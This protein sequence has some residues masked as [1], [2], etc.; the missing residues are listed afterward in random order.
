MAG[1]G[2]YSPWLRD[3]SARPAYLSS[4]GGGISFLRG[5]YGPDNAKLGDDGD[6]ERRNSPTWCSNSVAVAAIAG[7]AFASKIGLERRSAIA[8]LGDP[9]CPDGLQLERL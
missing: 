7:A 3:I 9:R 4:I 2:A 6:R 8:E 1:S 5:S